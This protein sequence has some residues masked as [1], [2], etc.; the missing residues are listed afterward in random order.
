VKDQPT[1]ERHLTDQELFSLAVPAAGEPE[2]LP[3][4]LSRCRDCSRALQEWK[5]AMRALAGEDI[6]ELD[7]R[8]PE[9][10]RA[11]EDATLSAVRRSGRMSRGRHSMRW[12]LGIAAS[13]LVVALAMP[14]R[15]GNTPVAAE[16]AGPVPELSPADQADDA[17]LREAEYLARG[18][19]DS[20]DLAVEESL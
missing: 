17:F 14:G 1:S 7:R 11:A 9:E 16:S 10:W 15:K 3:G 6:A 12:A 19:D 5:G 18:G 13:L 2:A 4:H 20:S 8:S